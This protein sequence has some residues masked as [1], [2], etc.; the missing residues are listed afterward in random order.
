[1]SSVLF[2]RLPNPEQLVLTQG[3]VLLKSRQPMTITQKRLLSLGIAIQRRADLTLRAPRVYTSDFARIFS[4]S[5]NSVHHTIAEGT[6]GLLDLKVFL[7]MG[8]GSFRG[9][10][11]VTEAAYI[12]QRKSEMGLAYS[13]YRFNPA[14]EA[15]LLNLEGHFQSYALLQTAGITRVASWRL[16][17]I[18]LADTLGFS[19]KRSLV[20]Y[21]LEQLQ[22]LLDATN[23]SWRDF[24]RDVLEQ[25]QDDHARELGVRWDYERVSH[26]RKVVG[27]ELQVLSVAPWRQGLTSKAEPEGVSEDDLDLITLKNELQEIGFTFDPGR[28]V[29][30][31]GAATMRA[32]LKRCLKEKRE[33]DTTAGGKPIGNLAGYV[34]ERFKQALFDARMAGRA[35]TSVPPEKAARLKDAAVARLATSLLITLRDAR[36]QHAKQLLAKYSEEKQAHVKAL[37]EAELD[38]LRLEIFSSQSWVTEVV[39][40][41]WTPF[42]IRL[43][44]EDFPKHLHSVRALVE[45]NGLMEDLSEA[46]KE[47]VVAEAERQEGSD[48]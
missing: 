9:Y 21:D 13:E 14:L 7:E 41:S 1:M 12:G 37:M 45:S 32:I 15:F 34:H 38:P 3:H 17:E 36:R 20:R 8:E 16:Y 30:E 33:R 5:G 10:N 43:F 48:A 28:Y 39:L 40:A 27:V 31:L 11:W 18:L 19:R 6:R 42:A 29:K 46:E 25:A 24:R 4:L 26:G 44:P 22:Y 47:R 2:D 35:T 23:F